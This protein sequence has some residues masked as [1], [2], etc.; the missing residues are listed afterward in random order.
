MKG[1]ERNQLMW[2]YKSFKK[3]NKENAVWAQWIVRDNQR[4][5]QKHQHTLTTL[6]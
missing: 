3:R 6:R 5:L 1:K 4:N 2:L